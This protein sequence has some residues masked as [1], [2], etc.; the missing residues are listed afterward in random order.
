MP[1]GGHIPQFSVASSTIVSSPTNKHELII[2]DAPDNMD[3]YI[4]NETER[5]YTWRESQDRNTSLYT[6]MPPYPI[7]DTN[8]PDSFPQKHRAI[9]SSPH[10]NRVYSH[11]FQQMPLQQAY[12]PSFQQM[13]LQQAYSPSFQQMPLWQAYPFQQMPR[14]YSIGP[15]TFSSSRPMSP[16]VYQ[17]GPVH[18]LPPPMFSAFNSRYPL[19]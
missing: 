16:F 18:F 10:V 14:H 19:Y 1:P 17:G 13:P 12:P 3:K 4:T 8:T 2:P 11:P 7:I 15:Q 9:T 5:D 6:T